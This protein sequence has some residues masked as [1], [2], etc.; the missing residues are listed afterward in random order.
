MTTHWHVHS[1]FT[2]G[3]RHLGARFALP[4]RQNGANSQ[5]APPPPARATRAGVNLA[6]S[7][8]ASSGPP[9]L[10]LPPRRLGCALYHRLAIA[11]AVRPVA[12][13]CPHLTEGGGS[14]SGFTS[15][16]SDASPVA[17]AR[18]GVATEPGGE[19]AEIGPLGT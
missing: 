17:A 3:R 9:G 7:R 19:L 12:I 16:L 13:E 5:C 1:R 2:A 14:T 10:R 15:L 8:R 11:D 18:G 6:R 4:A